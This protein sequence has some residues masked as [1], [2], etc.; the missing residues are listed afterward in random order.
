MCDYSL[1]NVPNRLAREGEELVAHRFASGS[2][3]LASYADLHPSHPPACSKRPFWLVL[4]QFL[5]PATATQV[6]AVC[7]PP[8]AHLILRDI[9]EQMQSE[10]GV[11][12]AEEDVTFTQLSAESHAYRDAVRF[13]NGHQ[14]LLQ[15]LREGQR[16]TVVALGPEEGPDRTLPEER[17]S[18]VRV[19]IRV[20]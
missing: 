10:L 18:Q 8:G 3:G 20:R 12:P 16:V 1:M 2:M 7:I 15:C 6:P 5:D 4:K 17:L 14:I 9:P 11:G 13:R 19:S